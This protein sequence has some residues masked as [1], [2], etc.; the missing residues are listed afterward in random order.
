MGQP[1]KEFG[2]ELVLTLLQPIKLGDLEFVD[3]T[4]TEPRGDTLLLADRED[5]MGA[6]FV[7][8]S[9]TASVSPV[10]AKR[11][12][13]RD[14]Q[15]AAHFFNHFAEL[16]GDEDFGDELALPL[17]EPI[18]FEKR[19]VTELTLSEPTGEALQLAD[20]EEGWGEVCALVAFTAG[21]PVDLVRKMRQRDLQR[22]RNFF[23]HFSDAPSS[24]PSATTPRS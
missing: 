24:R 15:R 3:L 10:I 7:K 11:M 22:A 18:E 2:D 19:T 9:R 4:L 6:L 23:V 5:A 13:Q 8:I 17:A 16:P 12:K 21:V 1:K 14:L 20:R